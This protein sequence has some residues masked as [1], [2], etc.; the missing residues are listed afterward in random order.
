MPNPFSFDVK[1]QKGCGIDLHKDSIK[2]CLMGTDIGVLVKDYGT[3]TSHLRLL[4]KDLQSHG[5]KDVIIESTGI[6][7]MPLHKLLSSE[8]IRV[9]IANPLGV[10]QIPGKKTDTTD[11]EWLCKLLING[12]VSPSFIPAEQVR[13]LRQLNRQRFLYVQSN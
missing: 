1:L 7:W 6:Y 13:Q 9:L 5:I 8:G 2:C 11:A 10:K 3:T 12:L 4:S